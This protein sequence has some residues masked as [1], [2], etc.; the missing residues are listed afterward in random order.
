MTNLPRNIRTQTDMKNQQKSKPPIKIIP[1]SGTQFRSH[2]PRFLHDREISESVAG[3][4]N[5]GNCFPVNER[6]FDSILIAQSS[7]VQYRIQTEWNVIKTLFRFKA[8]K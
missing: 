3:K 7:S 1:V 6:F 8:I 2:R 4:V 5:T